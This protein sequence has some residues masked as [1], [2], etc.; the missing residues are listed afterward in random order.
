MGDKGKEVQTS[1]KGK[2]TLA[3]NSLNHALN[4]NAPTK[5]MCNRFKE[6]QEAWKEVK[7]KQEEHINELTEYESEDKWMAELSQ[8]F[9][10]TE[11]KTDKYIFGRY[12]QE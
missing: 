1:A 3:N 4:E 10:E 8:M 11:I 9:D 2:F 6:F 12:T 5:T 7:E